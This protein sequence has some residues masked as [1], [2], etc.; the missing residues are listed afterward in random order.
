MKMEMKSM[1]DTASPRAPKGPT[2]LHFRDKSW[3]SERVERGRREIFAEVVTITPDIARGLLDQNADNRKLK[4]RMIAAA[5]RDIKAGHWELNGETIVISR[6]GELNDGQNRL[7]AI[8]R[9]DEAVQSF[10][11]F[12]ISRKSRLTVDMGYG[13]SAA[14]F[15]GMTKIPNASRMAIVSRLNLSLKGGMVAGGNGAMTKQDVIAHLQ[16]HRDEMLSAYKTVGGTKYAGSVKGW[17][18]LTVAYFNIKRVDSLGADLFFDALAV[19][20]NLDVD[21]PVLWLRARLLESVNHD[22]GARGD[23]RLEI[24]MR[25]WNAWARGEKIKKKLTMIGQYPKIVSSKRDT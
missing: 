14:E 6:D 7:H 25:Y 8:I 12:G 16:M 10:I 15:L 20:A 2:D 4:E 24:V 19:G 1:N 9:A 18:Y 17:A 21:D 13:R 11:A 23:A 5:A 22:K 3:F